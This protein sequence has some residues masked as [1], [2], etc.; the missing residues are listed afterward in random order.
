VAAQYLLGGHESSGTEEFPGVPFLMRNQEYH[1]KNSA[2]SFLKFR[3]PI[4]KFKEP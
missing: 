3:K 2:V 4:E 1:N